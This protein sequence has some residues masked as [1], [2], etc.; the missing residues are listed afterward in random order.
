MSTNA[1]TPPAHLFDLSE[2]PAQLAAFERYTQAHAAAL[3]AALQSDQQ[4]CLF[5][6]VKSIHAAADNLAAL[7]E[8]G[9]AAGLLDKALAMAIGSPLYAAML[10]ESNLPMADRAELIIDD[11]QGNAPPAVTDRAGSILSTSLDILHNL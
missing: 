6:L 5:D 10:V 7:V 8:W 1:Q 2:L 4:Q 9:R 11:L 3:D